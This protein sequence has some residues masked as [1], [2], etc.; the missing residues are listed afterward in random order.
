LKQG[1]AI[2]PAPLFRR[3]QMFIVIDNWNDQTD[4]FDTL[5]EATAY[6]LERERELD[7]HFS[8]SLFEAKE[9]EFETVHSIVVK[10]Q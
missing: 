8:L 7:Q 3:K 1:Q 10:P 9:L 6:I 5:E 2:K 4:K